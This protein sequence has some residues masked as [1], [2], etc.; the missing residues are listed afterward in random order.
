MKSSTAE[1]NKRLQRLETEKIAG[2][3]AL[4]AEK[5]KSANLANTIKQKEQAAARKRKHD[6]AAD[7]WGSGDWGDN[8]DVNAAE[9]GGGKPKRTPRCSYC[10]SKDHFF[11]DC[12]KAKEDG[13]G[14]GKK[15]DKGKG[16]QGGGKTPWWKLTSGKKGGS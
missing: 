6:E 12:P 15:G 7:D 3:T 8:A 4:A 16:K 1:Q 14:K 2:A 13:R 11:R 5:A 10:E 9:K